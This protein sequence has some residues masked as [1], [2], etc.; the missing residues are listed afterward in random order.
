MEISIKKTGNIYTAQVAN[1]VVTYISA[2]NSDDFTPFRNGIT[3][4][5]ITVNEAFENIKK[6]INKYITAYIR[7]TGDSPKFASDGY[8]TIIIDIPTQEI[9]NELYK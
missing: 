3:A 7:A 4:T 6:N 5:G 2:P 8:A 9:F 1:P